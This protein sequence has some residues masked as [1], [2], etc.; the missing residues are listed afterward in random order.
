MRHVVIW[1]I[2][3]HSCV[4]LTVRLENL[5]LFQ[6]EQLYN[7]KGPVKIFHI[8]QQLCRGTHTT[9]RRRFAC[10]TEILKGVK[11]ESRREFQ[12]RSRHKLFLLGIHILPQD[13]MLLS[14]PSTFAVSARVFSISQ[15]TST[16]LKERRLFNAFH[17]M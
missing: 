13:I 6:P 2:S 5:S 9:N 7:Y 16:Y 14:L 4:G 10:E 11:K 3:E 8:Y 17:K 1:F 12:R 15:H